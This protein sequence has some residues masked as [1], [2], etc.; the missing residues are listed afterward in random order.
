MH[1][2][3]PDVRLIYLVRDPIDRAVAGWHF[4]TRHE[5]EWRPFE[6]AFAELEDNLHVAR[7]RYAMQLDRYL[8]H[9]PQEQ[10]LV[11]DSHDLRTDRDTT[12]SRIYGFVGVDPTFT[13]PSFDEQMQVADQGRWLSP[14]G[15]RIVKTLNHTIGPKTTARIGSLVPKRMNVLDRPAVPRPVASDELRERL[16]ELLA[17]DVE[18]LRKLTGQS[19][20][21][22]SI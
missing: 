4:A 16:T 10:I 9:F 14:N 1:D 18:R 2:V 11:V 15:L 22:W 8:A 13:S 7:S 3:I 12:L 17:P 21:S 20:A 5:D 19:F 6:T